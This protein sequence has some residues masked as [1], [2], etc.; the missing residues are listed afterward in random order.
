MPAAEPSPDTVRELAALAG[1]QLPE[2]DVAPVAAALAAQAETV[3]PLLAL[4]LD[5]VPSA[6]D[7]D[8]RWP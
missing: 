5:E 3:A 7:F 2:E 6:L 1:I 4:G 8:P